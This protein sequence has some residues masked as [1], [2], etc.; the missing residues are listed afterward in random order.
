MRVIIV[1]AGPVG[2][3]L[4]CLL[5]KH[6][7]DC[8]ILER[9]VARSTHSR[10]IGIHPP[11]LR[12]LHALGVADALIDR[13]IRVARG[14]GFAEGRPLGVLSFE[15]LPPPFPF[16]LAVP[17]HVTESVL[18]A[19]FESLGEPVRRGIDVTA[20]EQSD[21]Y[22]NIDGEQA[23]WVIACDGRRSTVRDL[24]GIPF[25][26]ASYDEH[27]VM[28]D[29]PDTTVFGEDAAIYLHREG[30]VECF[31]L[32]GRTRRWVA[33]VANPSDAKE[34]S[35]LQSMLSKAVARRTGE[36]LPL[37]ACSMVSA[38][39]AERFEAERFVVGRAALA[40]DPPHVISPIGGQ[41]MNLGWMD[42]DWLAEWFAN[43][44]SPAALSHY[45][46]VRKKSFRKAARRSELNMFVGRPGRL[47]PIRRLFARLILSQP[48]QARFARL[49]TMDSL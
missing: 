2:L 11:A 24:L 28:G 3:Y 9:R 13:G 27:Y 40:G 29:F 49:F 20:L 39:T 10:S 47:Y 45:E 35:Q 31:P 43:G 26:G 1:G 17:Q 36:E 4:G 33:R 42:A 41:G 21:S 18:E 46:R 7:V 44:A 37:D 22:V 16:V 38:F 32:P 23:D 25:D 19:L 15:A 30:V 6:G 14:Q 5:R 34:D 12:R 48:F 8:T